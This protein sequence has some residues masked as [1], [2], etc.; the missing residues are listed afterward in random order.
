MKPTQDEV[1]IA[2]KQQVKTGKSLILLTTIP[3]ILVKEMFEINI[4]KQIKL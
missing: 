2:M 3:K 1:V 4:N